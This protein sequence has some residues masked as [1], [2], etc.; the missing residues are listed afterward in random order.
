MK[1]C[2]VI[3]RNYLPYARV[4][5]RS[6]EEHDGGRLSVLILDDVDGEVDPRSEPFDVIR[7]EEL[8]LTRRQFHVMATIYDVVELA[9]SVKPWLFDL[10]LDRAGESICYLDPD[11]EVF[12]PLDDVRKLADEHGI[13]LA[14]H[15]TEPMPR[16]GLFPDETYILRAGVY[17]LGF[18]ALSPA[19]VDF[20]EWW[21]ERLFRDCRIAVDEG[22]FVDQ[23]WIDLVPAL[24]DHAVIRDRGI[25]VAYWNLATREISRD[26]STFMIGDRPLRLFH[27]SG[28]SPLSP[29]VL[30]RHQGTK[31]RVLLADQPA[32]ARICSRYAKKLLDAGYL[33]A[34]RHVYRFDYTAN[35][36]PIDR[37]LRS[38]YR[39]LLKEQEEEE[40]HE[41]TQWLP[42][43][44]DPVQVPAFFRSMLE[45]PEDP[46]DGLVPRYFA[47]LYRS[48]ADL[49]LAF[50]GLEET[51]VARYL[52]WVERTA[53]IEG[54][55]PRRYLPPYR[56]PRGHLTRP[57][58]EP[59]KEGVNVVG[60]LDA[61][62]GVGE[63]CRQFGKV[64]T[65]ADIEHSL[66][67]YGSTPSRRLA[68][69][70]YPAGTGQFDI[71]L[72]CVNADKLPILF[73]GMTED[74]HRPHATVAVWAWEVAR[75]PEWM[76]ASDYL[77][78]EIWVYSQ[79]AARAIAPT[80][81][82]SVVVVPPS[83]AAP[84]APRL[85]RAELGLPEGF[86][87]LMCFSYLSVFERKN[88]IAVVE[89]FRRAFHAG[90]GPQLVIKSIQGWHFPADRARLRAAAAGRPDIHFIDAYESPSRQQALMA[91]CDA[92]VSL[93][94]A[95]GY[96]LT[97]AEAMTY[98]KPVIGTG[99]SGNLEFMN[100]EN[101]FL[102]PFQFRPVPLGCDPYP[103]GTPWAEPDVE[104]AAELMRRV[105]E[106]PVMAALAG[107]R[108]REDMATLHSPSARTELV[109]SRLDKLRNAL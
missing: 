19:T 34:Q 101:S 57:R 40:E 39:L 55:V 37:Q 44:F 12:G 18:I 96:G 105:V 27:F 58:C 51:G 49:Q 76:R 107:A 64:L 17:N 29:H 47:D 98:G 60:Y 104:A 10:M 83:L 2:T 23:R 67:P 5:A 102:V 81:D 35:G 20:R 11:I 68:T 7:P 3:A 28:F 46:G 99:Y 75:F 72:I 95:E 80:T 50:P 103:A 30:S 9:T 106:D 41:S 22:I 43:P 78:D 82:K 69:M 8:G 14:P 15:L 4:L 63:V 31:A 94:R 54:A 36:D 59:L 53:L 26:G 84:E 74:F 92:Y 13:V 89:A 91:A 42:D 109:R 61:E 48:R 93:H 90:E 62:D 45:A 77:V 56:P 87:F 66:I 52:E 70:P 6:L 71:S 32:L 16:D 97:M 79:H 86:L 88:P 1:V 73:A 38:T 85:S 25:D 108:A 65:A 21:K 24:F 33:E 100:D